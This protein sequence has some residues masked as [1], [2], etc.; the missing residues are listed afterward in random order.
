MSRP[1][2]AVLL[3]LGLAFGMCACATAPNPS[4]E[5][6]YAEFQALNDPLEPLNRQTFQLNQALDTMFLRPA[7]IFYLNI[8][9]PPFQRGTN[10]FL[11]NLRSPVIVFNDL[12][13]LDFSRAGNTAMRFIINTTLGVLGLDERAAEFGYPLR[14]NDFG[15]TLAVWGVPEGPYL[16]L[17]ALGPSSPRDAAGKAVDGAIL[18]PLG[19]LGNFDSSLSDLAWARLGVSAVNARARVDGEYED[20][21]RTSLDFYAAVRSLYRQM[22]AGQVQRG[23]G[24][25]GMGGIGGGTGPDGGP[26]FDDYPDYRD[27]PDIPESPDAPLA[28][29]PTPNPAPNPAPSTN[30]GAASPA[31]GQ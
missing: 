16:I 12:L 2:A 8:I 1:L 30:G 13:Q 18:D 5:A 25:R 20:L 9:P 19:V 11:N 17:P 29:N 27:F 23:D 3:C 14:D 31:T 22:R 10:N 21:K 15:Q 6:A 7:A 28:P 4:D 26:A 24:R